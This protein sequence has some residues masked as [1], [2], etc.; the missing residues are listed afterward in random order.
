MTKTIVNSKG[1][2]VPI[3][4]KQ[5]IIFR[6][7]GRVE[8]ACEHGVGH[9]IGHLRKWEQWMGIHGCDGCCYKAGFC[10]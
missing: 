9:P 10:L 4:N 1:E 2:T 5:H 6:S 8:R 7:D 3:P